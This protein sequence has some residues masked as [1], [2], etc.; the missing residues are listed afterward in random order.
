MLTPSSSPILRSMQ[1]THLHTQTTQSGCTRASAKVPV[2][3]TVK[4]PPQ[5]EIITAAE[6]ANLLDAAL[7]IN[8]TTYPKQ[9]VHPN[10]AIEETSPVTEDEDPE[11]DSIRSLQNYRQLCDIL[12]GTSS[13]SGIAQT[14]QVSNKTVLQCTTPRSVR[15]I[16]RLRRQ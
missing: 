9:I 15:P 6:W 11:F 16:D 13:P 12:D 2:A 14:Q 3:S 1:N 8:Q 10:G 4:P 7:E 5:Q